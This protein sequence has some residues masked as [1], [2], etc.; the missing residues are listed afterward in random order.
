MAT[1]IQGTMREEAEPLDEVSAASRP[2]KLDAG[3]VHEQH[4]DFV[5]CTLQR[6]NVPQ[7]DLEDVMQEVFLVVHRRLHTFDGSSKLT[8]WLFGICI[9]VVAGFRRR[10]YRVRERST[11]R[12]LREQASLQANPEAAL[13]ESQARQRLST[14]LESLPLDKRAVFVMFEI[15]GID[16]ATIAGVVG[17]PVGTVHSRLYAARQDFEKAVRRL[18]AREANRGGR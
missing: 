13:A 16:C 2:E 17:V 18:L 15:E 7:A 6:L 5:W 10:A 12:P 14:V 9:R 8:T 11:D 1:S 4:A 3:I